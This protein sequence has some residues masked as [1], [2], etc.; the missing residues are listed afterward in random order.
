LW[1]G[2]GMLLL[3]SSFE[4]CT[5]GEETAPEEGDEN[6]EGFGRLEIQIR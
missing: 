2:L 4:E 3:F 6:C 1:H 5:H